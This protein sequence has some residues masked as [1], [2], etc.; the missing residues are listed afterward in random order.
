MQRAKF[1]EDTLGEK[2]A[3][4]PDSLSK[5]GK[6]IYKIMRDDSS[7]SSSL[8]PRRSL[9]QFFY[10]SLHNTTSRDQDQVLSKYM[11]KDS[12]G[13]KKMIMVDQLWLW[14]L[15]S[16]NTKL[17]TPDKTKASIKTTIFTSFPR[18]QREAGA[19]ENDLED[20]ADLR[21]AIIDEANG[22][23]VEQAADRCF[24]I[25]LIIEQAVNVMLRVRTEESLDV[26]EV[27]RAAIGE[28]VSPPRL[29]YIGSLLTHS[30]PIG[31][32][33]N[34]LLS[35][36]PGENEAWFEQRQEFKCPRWIPNQTSRS[37]ACP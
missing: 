10:S 37:R 27:F 36:L 17:N 20:I 26:L 24:Y 11:P 33:A 31:R 7:S 30:N 3:D 34:Q 29:L 15:E 6:A 23:D 18:K 25:G 14:L 8:H 9:D 5:E 19:V 16:H 12:R 28:A 21:Q 35:R 22:I 13:G 32:K 1:T 2:S 4:I